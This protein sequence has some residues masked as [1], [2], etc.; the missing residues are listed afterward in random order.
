MVRRAITLV[1]ASVALLGLAAC[2]H[3]PSGPQP[4]TLAASDKVP[5][6]QGEFVLA[7]SADGNTK[8]HLAVEHMAPASRVASGATTYVVWVKPLASDGKPQNVGALQV[9][10]DL[11]G[12]LDSVTPL[13]S[14]EV[15][16]TPEA[17][18]S[19]QQPSGQA[20]LWG[21]SGE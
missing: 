2:S 11:Q 21:R 4:V 16:V 10:Q 8:I 18:A 20:L 19:V 3:E 13:K 17:S 14:F 9:N 7:Q 15:F 6:A 12:T 5:A 1:V